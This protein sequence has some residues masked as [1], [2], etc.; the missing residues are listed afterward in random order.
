MTKSRKLL[1]RVVKL[2]IIAELAY[3]VL[4]NTALQIPFTQDLVNL[5]RPEK[6]QVNWDRAWTLYP[7]RVYASGVRA[8]G[9]SR[10][11]QWQ[12]S[13]DDASANI[14][15]LCLVLKRV[16][17]FDVDAHN[18]DYRQR[19]LLKAG[20]DYSKLLSHFPQIEGRDI[21]AA[22]TSPRKKKRP[23]KLSVN[24]AH[25]DGTVKV[26][27][28]NLQLNAQGSALADLSFET[29]GGLFSLDARE[30]DLD[31][32]PA[33]I[34]GEGE[35]FKGGR[36]TGKLG[37]EP[38][39]PRENKGLGML[40]FLQLDTQLDLEL[41]SLDFINLFTADMGDFAIDGAGK[42]SGRIHYGLGYMRAGTKLLVRVAD[43]SVLVKNMEI[44]GL[45]TVQISTPT[46]DDMSLQLEISYDTSSVTRD[47]DP[48]PFLI[49]DSLKLVY[50]GPN[51]IVPDT[52][53]KF[54]T[55][56]N[57]EERWERRKDSTLMVNIDDA[58]LVDLTILNE[59]LP[60]MTALKFTSGTAQLEANIFAD[61]Q[62]VEGSLQLQGA[63]L[64]MRADGQ[65]LQG[66]LDV[67][68]VIVGG[69]PRKRQ[70]DLTGSSII[71]DEVNVVGEQQTFD[72]KN[73]SARVLLRRAEVV[74]GDPL[75][76]SADADLWISDTR[77]LV[78]L[79]ENHSNPP[80]WVSRM[81]ITSDIE[82]DAR[83]ELANDRLEISHARIVSDKAEIALKAVFYNTGRDGMLYA[84]YKKL[85][86][87][88]KMEGD[89]SNI[90]VIRARKKFD[91][92]Q[93][94]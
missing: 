83:V 37:F 34:N 36:V 29:G 68:L 72:D 93:L 60:T 38:F 79:F 13:V 6:F 5:I 3:L 28:H 22:D 88:L 43:L 63:G 81:L 73:W 49:G 15:L 46:E 12:L 39:V 75:S 77:P 1:L 41:G 91:E 90:D 58:T 20:K 70:I 8:N 2:V 44:V 40:S 67:E 50:S 11:Q 84:R 54:K 85:G 45:G 30:V 80:G 27:I 14:S 47:G 23:W 17:L 74:A 65:D 16:N 62:T 53:I 56:L 89:S 33:Y 31:L 32:S 26:W 59:Y 82:G 35:L 10:S 76:F 66:D 86:I 18:V 52:N 57:D 78:A 94:R 19:P 61:A 7:F 21:Q 64:G 87:V 92:Y 71:L 25:V 51:Y 48:S 55:L 4:V 69:V 9:Q 24:K 42:L